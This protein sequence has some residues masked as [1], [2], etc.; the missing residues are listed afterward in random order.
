MGVTIGGLSSGLPPNIVDQL[1]DAERAPIKALNVKKD[2]QGAKMKLVDELD[3]KLKAIEG[4]I[5]GLAGQKG[6]NDIKLETGDANVIQGSVDAAMAPKGNWNVEVLELAQKASAITNGFPDK[7][8]TEVG[9]GYIKFQT[10]E[11]AKEI[12][13]DGS[14]NTLEGVA[15][16]VNSAGLGIKANV[17]NDRKDPENPYRLVFAGEAVGGEKSVEFPTLY[18]LDGDQDLYFDD[19][20]EAKNGRIKV[21]GFEFEI[22]DN[23]VKDA[24][25]GVVLDLKQA[26]PGKSVNISVKEN[27]EVVNTKVGEFVK[28]MND[29]LAF[30]QSQSQINENTDTSKTLGGDSIIRSTE[31]R[32]RRLIQDPQ[33][34]VAGNIKRLNQIGIEL[35]RNGQLKLTEDKFNSVLSGNPD[36]VRQFF[37]GDGFNTG[38]VPTLRREI[39][40]LTNAAFGPVAMRKKSLQD[41]IK[42]MDDDIAN[43]ERQLA[44]KEEDLRNKFSKLEQTMSNLKQQGQAV[45]AMGGGGFQG[46]NL[47]GAQV[48]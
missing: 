20:R 17:I 29:A 4:S 24:I 13:I 11:G 38:F 39:S 40:T 5:G 46:P 3:T 30:L 15:N 42:R 37:A 18:F 12:Y 14:S 32:L 27:K 35:Q 33:Y 34:G 10:P 28:S 45:G 19:Q 26:S 31:N 44:R 7:D 9:V 6:F 16:K 23:T 1:V 36:Q 47:G 43:K 21:D 41:N 8:K 2:K 48:S 25:P 22:A